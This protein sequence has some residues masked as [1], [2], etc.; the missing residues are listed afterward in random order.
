MLRHVNLQHYSDLITNAINR[1]L[2]DGK[3]R[4]KDLGGHNTTTEF[5]YAVIAN[6]Q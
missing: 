6:L 1:V 3:I 2:Q 4:T 5:T